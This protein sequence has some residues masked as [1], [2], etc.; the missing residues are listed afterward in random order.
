VR[1][2]RNSGRGRAQAEA[3]EEVSLS[4][5]ALTHL[6]Q[7]PGSLDP[8]DRCQV[9]RCK[10]EGPGPPCRPA[11]R[12]PPWTARLSLPRD[13][14]PKRCCRWLS[15]RALPPGLMC[16]AWVRNAGDR[17]CPLVRRSYALC[18]AGR[19]RC[20]A[21]RVGGK[22]LRALHDEISPRP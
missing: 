17:K 21:M 15:S 8:G 22:N 4:I 20:A 6:I 19:G 3:R 10:L 12:A 5:R 13:K 1:Q 16:R 7:P 9:K 2:E 14:L 18:W 11:I